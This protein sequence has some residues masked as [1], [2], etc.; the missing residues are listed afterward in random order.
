M[1]NLNKSRAIAATLVATAV[2]WRVVNWHYSWAPNL[3]IVTASTLV[4]GA[5]LSRRMV[6][7]VPL[8]IM[9][10]SDLII[11][12]SSI[13]LF[14]WSAFG[15]IGLG[16]LAL[17]RL[18]SSPGKLMLASVGAA[19]AGSVFFFIYTNFGV[20]LLDD[21]AMYDK[22]WQGLV[23]CYAM[24]LPFYR[25]MLLGNMVLV[26]AYFAAALYGPGMVRALKERYRTRLAG[27]AR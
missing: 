2:L 9:A 24:G 3:E 14:T 23:Q 25:T 6:L 15:L 26:P 18:K 19:L 27:V 16:S 22:T 7:V 11:S 17:R 10:A 1:K 21:G 12:N 5:L 4:A 20:W 8:G 13:L